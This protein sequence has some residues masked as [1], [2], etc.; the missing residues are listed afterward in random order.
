MGVCNCSIFCCTLRYVHS[1]VR[2][3]DKNKRNS[4][5]QNLNENKLIQ[6]NN[7]IDTLIQQAEITNSDVN[8]IIDDIESLFQ[9]TCKD[10][11]GTHAHKKQPRTEHSGNKPWFNRECKNA[12]NI[13]HKIRR[14]YNKYKTNYFKN[15]LKTVSK[16]YKQ[17][18]HR[19]IN[20]FKLDKIEKLKSLKRSNPREYWRIINNNKGPK[21]QAPLDDLF[22][23]FKKIN[24]PPPEH[25]ETVPV[26]GEVQNY[27]YNEAINLP[28][29]TEEI[30]EAVAALQNN[31]SPGSDQILNEHI[32]STLSSL[33]PIYLKLFNIIFDNGIFP[34]SWV[35]GN[36]IPIYKNKGKAQNPENYRPITLLSC[37][38]KLFTRI[39]SNRLTKY[40]EEYNL[41]N[42]CQA[43]FR[44]GYSTT[45]NLFI[46]NSLIDIMKM[47]RQKLYC[48]FIDFKQ[49]FDTVWRN[50]LWH[51][52]ETYCINGK[53][54]KLIQNL[55]KNIKSR[56]KTPEGISAFFPCKIGVR[57]GENLSPFLF[58][59][60]LNDLEHYLKMHRV[61]SIKCEYN[62]DD[63]LIF[64]KL[65]L[66]LYADDT[67][68]F[69][70]SADELQNALNVFQEY[71]KTWKLT[72][73]ITKT[74]ILII[75]KGRPNLNLHFHYNN[76]EIEIVAEYKYLGIYL[77][78]SGNYRTA[79]RHIAEQAE[80]A[81]FS[82]IR[83][84]RALDLPFDIQID[85]FNKTIKPILLYG[86]EI[87]GFGN[88]DII[89]RVQLKFYKYIFNLKRTTPSFMIYGELG[90]TPI[91][92]DIKARVASFWSKIIE[93]S[94]GP[95]KLSHL[96]YNI[97][98]NLHKNS[99]FKSS[100]AENVK[101]IIES[102][103]FSGFWITQSVPNPKWF[104]LAIA[105]KLKDQYMQEWATHLKTASSGTNYRL[106]K[107]TLFK[108]QYLSILSNF[109]CK[110][111]IAFRT[112]NHRLPIETGRWNGIAL[113]ERKCSFCRL[114]IGD[115]FHF[116]MSCK[117]F[118]TARKRLIKKYYYDHPSTLKFRQLMN[119]ENE[120]DLKKLCRLIIIINEAFNN[121]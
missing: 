34:E 76:S 12:R 121:V 97:I 99:N 88:C 52:L 53:C 90:I 116:I 57:Q 56:I 101:N 118:D 59:I 95:T 64:C 39:I 28:I 78:R 108:S 10:T 47:K 62:D 33:L 17:T 114:D 79:K 29:T 11:F 22:N 30:T 40:A 100:F 45:D 27:P 65:L 103:G 84:I 44:K 50:G 71:C 23:Y 19:N 91:I 5:V 38:G 111:F 77:S 35:L 26:Q 68:I 46:I 31:K 110:K 51:K 94:D 42:D 21:C 66:L 16:D 75:S 4:Y 41:L 24:N 49:A 74:K 15:L 54:L 109:Y 67:V 25:D 6:I 107:D 48:A 32:K 7:D 89:E 98:Y 104:S 60:F 86:S 83:K 3:W 1:T 93:P 112:R 2:L 9:E 92:V 63:I 61:Q 117:L 102:C 87:W 120:T 73:N 8:H 85:M 105:Q 80:K 70:E 13:Y 96:L 14:L 36:I 43:G 115:E 58:A 82:L 55:Y 20:K 106:F 119:T 72:V 113:D 69:S 18:M 81:L 37:V